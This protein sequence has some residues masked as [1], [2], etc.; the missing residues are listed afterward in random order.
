[1]N[2]PEAKVTAF[3]TMPSPVGELLLLA[4]GPA[5]THCLFAEER[6]T[7]PAPGWRDGSG[8]PLLLEARRQLRAYFARELSEFS[9]PLAPVG[10]PFQGKV[11]QQ[12]Q[13]IPYGTTWSYRD[14]AQRIDH[15]KAYRA[16][17]LANGQN[18]LSIIVPCHRVIGANGSLVGYGG[19]LPR[20]TWLL[21]LEQGRQ[22][23]GLPGA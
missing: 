17:G 13:L 10:T 5:L 11:W 12:L 23:L 15:P 3:L 2:D 18:P 16:V 6:T 9:L 4:D 20:K 1:M 14:L 19:G 8:N 22:A 21:D 7:Q